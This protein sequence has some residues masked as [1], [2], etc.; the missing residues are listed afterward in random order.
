MGEWENGKPNFRWKAKR[1]AQ[2]EFDLARMEIDAE[3]ARI[4][5]HAV[6]GEHALPTEPRT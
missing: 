5:P 2:E 4:I 6:V 1:A 3:C